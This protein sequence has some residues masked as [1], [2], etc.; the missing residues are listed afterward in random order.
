MGE[1]RRY[2]RHHPCPG[3]LAGLACCYA[4]FGR[5]EQLAPARYA[6]MTDGEEIHSAVYPDTGGTRSLRQTAAAILVPRGG[7]YGQDQR[8]RP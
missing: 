7:W 8:D 3:G 4:G 6:M 2:A 5:I 1:E